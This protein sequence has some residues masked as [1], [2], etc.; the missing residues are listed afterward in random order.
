V[1]LAHDQIQP[2]IITIAELQETVRALLYSQRGFPEIASVLDA[3]YTQDWE[4][5]AWSLD[6]PNFPAICKLFDSPFMLDL[7]GREEN[8]AIACADK[9]NL[10]SCN[11]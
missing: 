10:V 6:F 3:A 9:Q 5:L 2:K 7:R 4:R 8:Q 11:H 1:F